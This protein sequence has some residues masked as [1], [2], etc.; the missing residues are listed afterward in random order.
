MTAPSQTELAEMLQSQTLYVTGSTNKHKQGPGF[1]RDTA[2]TEDPELSRARTTLSSYPDIIEA[3]CSFP[4]GSGKEENVKAKLHFAVATVYSLAELHQA[5]TGGSHRS[6][7]VPS[8]GLYSLSRFLGKL[9]GETPGEAGATPPPVY[10]SPSKVPD[11]ES[12]PGASN[13]HCTDITL[14]AGLTELCINEL[15]AQYQLIARHGSESPSLEDAAGEKLD[16]DPTSAVSRP[17]SQARAAL[18]APKEQNTPQIRFEPSR[19][20]FLNL[21]PDHIRHSTGTGTG[22]EQLRHTYALVGNPQNPFN[23]K[24]YFLVQLCRADTAVDPN[25]IS[26]DSAL[27]KKAVEFH[28]RGYSLGAEDGFG[29][30][31]FDSN[32]CSASC[33]L[34]MGAKSSFCFNTSVQ[35]CAN[36]TL[37]PQ[38]GVRCVDEAVIER[39]EQALLKPL[40][41]LSVD[42]TAT[43]GSGAGG[44]GSKATNPNP[45]TAV[46]NDS[47]ML[48]SLCYWRTCQCEALPLNSPLC[49]HSGAFRLCR[50]HAELQFY[51]ESRDDT[52]SL[53]QQLNKR[54]LATMSTHRSG[55]AAAQVW[56]D[57][58]LKRVDSALA[59]IVPVAK[60]SSNSEVW[61]YLPKKPP[62]LSYSA[63]NRDY[64]IIMAASTLLQEL[65]SANAKLFTTLSSFI[66]KTIDQEMKIK[67][68][69][70]AVLSYVNSV[71]DGSGAAGEGLGSLALSPA[72]VGGTEGFA[73]DFIGE[74]STNPSAK[75]TK[76]KGSTSNTHAH[77]DLQAGLPP[78]AP[79]Q[80][81]PEVAGEL[82]Q[83]C[84]NTVRLLR[85]KISMLMS[86]YLA[87]QSWTRW[88]VP[89]ELHK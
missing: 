56:T 63:D 74:K 47:A 4:P 64:K 72:K 57:I 82:Q 34:T 49:A 60:V 30:G 85:K 43:G 48:S 41:L 29:P 12:G 54:S 40:G 89:D 32:S 88:R 51:L 55:D 59:G 37:G 14:M 45:K 69:L 11:V 83:K 5:R 46:D 53:Y 61:K 44:K 52:P 86:S 18:S 25:P 73:L 6:E 76:R 19:P 38:A 81:H 10:T 67:K 84:L 39:Q 66:N 87:K 42:S 21:L 9:L 58:K 31:L 7:L 65:C 1:S 80:A 78:A 23:Q 79:T 75:K 24:Q 16:A 17:S 68:R 26:D 22:S 20:G 70:Y 28:T 62:K 35:A 2:R 71:I 3:E 33:C 50:Y 15:L 13:A 36:A 27:M 77:A 8:A